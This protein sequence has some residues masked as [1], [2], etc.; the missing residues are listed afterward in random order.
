MPRRVHVGK[1]ALVRTSANA[2]V[3]LA[4]LA[5]AAL[6]LAPMAAS[7]Q[8]IHLA[9]HPFDPA[10]GE[11]KVE[12]WLRA[13]D[14]ARGEQGYYLVQLSGSP[15]DARK[16]AVAAAGGEIIAYVPDNTYIVRMNGESRGILDASSAIR[17]IGPY[18]PAYKMSPTIGKHEFKDPRR[19][20]DSFLT[21][22]VR[23][24]DD[25]EWT[26]L[27]MDSLGASV[28]EFS[29]D[30]FQKLLVVHASP[31]ILPAIARIPNV[32]WIEEKPEC[33]I[34]NDTTKWVVQSNVS[35]STP[36]WDKGIHG[37]GQLAAVMDTGIDYNSCWFREVGGAA[38]GPSHRK[39]VSYAL[40]GGSAYDGCDVGHGT[41]V[42]GTL[43]GDQ[44]YVNPGNLS[45]NGMAYK[46]KLAIQDIGADDSWSCTTGQVSVPTSLTQAYTDAY[47]LGARIHSNSWGSTEN[48]YGSYCV[49]VDNFMWTHQDFLVVFA[50]GNSGP[51]AST[52]GYPGTA[53]NCVTVGA[54]QRPPGQNTVAGY[55]SRGPASDSRTKPTIAAP[56][57]EASSSYVNS[58]DN[59]IGNPPAET[60]NVA[61]SPFQG[62]S[63]ATPA[64]AG[65]AALTRQYYTEGWYP[66]GAKTTDDEFTPSAALLKA[67][68]M[69]SA[70]DM[71][72]ADIPNM[73]E[74]W[75]RVLLEDALYFDGDARELNVED[76]TPGVSQGGSQT[77]EIEVDSSSVPL[78]IVLVWTD[79]PATAGAGVALVNNLDLTVTAPGGTVYKGNVFSGGQ[80]TS[81]GSYDSRTVEEVVRLA[82]PP[83]GA[84]TVR[85]DGTT[86]PHGPQPF[87]LV[88]TGSFGNWPPET[89][90]PGA[91]VVEGSPFEV[92]AIA[93]NPFNPSTTITYTLHPVETGKARTALRVYSVDGRLVTTL[94]DRVQD[95]G[96]HAVTWDGLDREGY[97]AASGIYFLEL[98]YGGEKE[99][100]KMTLLK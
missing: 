32:W 72:T 16:E 92:N 54:T 9:T 100:R 44:S 76:V 46:A 87:A 85:I 62:T 13:D 45:Y 55:S 35:G 6:V 83:A 4:A 79:Y 65:C 99:S 70:T 78:E 28:L 12:S 41:H 31:Q 39:V 67:T 71:A 74:G 18:H 49:D 52:V 97:A 48:S 60:C 8:T 17:W 56:G 37:E 68:V 94:V 91:P 40:Y 30:G 22:V 80:S 61:S 84:Y 38:P 98:S 47:G 95:P 15:T 77:F 43:A 24:F 23:V 75:G 57:G 64:V 96:R 34:M 86:V 66:S 51:D 88:S 5:A 42:C 81:G 11:P 58:A 63:M 82:S 29:D 26:A 59:D 93:P 19:A 3:L 69:N 25:L 90:I 7:A 53:K 21:L 33:T 14:P 73:N 10:G 1:E 20:K 27:A 50:A 89:G 36:I 2:V